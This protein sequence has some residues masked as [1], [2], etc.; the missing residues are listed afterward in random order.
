[1]FHLATFSSPIESSPKASEL[2][3]FAKLSS[4]RS[5]LILST[6]LQFEVHRFQNDFSARWLHLSASLFLTVS[7]ELFSAETR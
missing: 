1:M 5:E 4:S 2:F 7:Y 3:I 6:N